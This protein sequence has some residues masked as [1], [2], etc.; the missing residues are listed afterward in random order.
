MGVAAAVASV[1][2]LAEL[3]KM[4][5]V[6]QALFQFAAQCIAVW[7][8]RRRGLS[9]HDSYRMPLYPLPA[10]IALAGW[11]YVAVSSGFHYVAIG[12]V[13]VRPGV[14][15]TFSKRGTNGSGPSSIMK[16]YDIAVIGEIYV[17]HVLT[18]FAK[19]PKPGEEVFTNEYVKELGG[20]AAIT[21]CALAV[22]DVGRARGRGG[23]AQMAWVSERLASLG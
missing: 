1:F 17:D 13:M 2:T 6:V 15:Y 4:L 16:N 21:A 12:M 11:I 7:L 23:P 3:I 8:V 22:W 5:I 20:G 10:V 19:W 18:G 14:E 9:G